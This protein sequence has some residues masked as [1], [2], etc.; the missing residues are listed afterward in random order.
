MMENVGALDD[1]IGVVM[2]QG[3]Y[4]FAWESWKVMYPFVEITHW[5]TVS[6]KK[7]KGKPMSI[8][9]E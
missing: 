7:Q 6:P 3:E 5:V 4:M 8:T 1:G 2:F 9:L